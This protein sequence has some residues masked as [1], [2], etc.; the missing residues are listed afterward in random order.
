[1]HIVYETTCLV[2]GKKYIGVHNKDDDDYLGSGKL[3]R[4][5]IKRYGRTKFV[6]E[7]LF[8]YNTAEEAY[9]KEAELVTPEVCSSHNYYNINLGGFQPPDCTGLKRKNTQKYAEANSR[10]W[11]DPEYRNRLSKSMSEAW[12]RTPERADRLRTQNIGRKLSPEHTEKT[13]LKG[14]ITQCYKV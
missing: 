7:T 2:N 4:R 8:S 6:R 14:R 5:A 1:M 11:K 10:K 13:T 12:K 3:I 9:A